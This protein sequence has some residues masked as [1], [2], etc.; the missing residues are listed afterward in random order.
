MDSY[1]DLLSRAAA[2]P[3]VL[4]LILTGSHAR[5]MAGPASDHDVIVVVSDERR[6]RPTSRSAELDEIV[7]TRDQ[8]ADTSDEWQRY[9]FRGARILLDRTDG[10]LAELVQAQATL[11][12]SEAAAWAR[13]G[14]DGYLNQIYRAAKNRRDGA[15]VLAR[16]EEMES[17][18][19]FMTA[20]FAMHGRVRPY[21]K[22]LR[23]ELRTFPLGEPW[24]ADTLPERLADDPSGLFPDLERL[25]RAKGHGDVLDA[26][27]P[28]LDLL[29][30]E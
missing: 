15:P 4:G 30:R 17:V 21:H 28:D 1:A 3:D 10:Q 20:L 14:L 6:W 23:W 24:H 19:W 25:A 29:R 12:G 22:Y 13:E 16:L 8:L 5:G 27:G 2:N 11:T 9:A 7:Y 26:W 18:S